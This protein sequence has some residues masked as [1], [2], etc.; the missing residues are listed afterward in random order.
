MKTAGTITIKR[1]S[2]LALLAACVGTI[3]LRAQAQQ[4]SQDGRSSRQGQ[5]PKQSQLS[6]PPHAQPAPM[7]TYRKYLESEEGRAM[8][9]VA[10][11]PISKYLND[12]FGA[13]SADALAQ[14]RAR[15]QKIA[16]QP[17]PAETEPAEG[18]GAV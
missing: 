10:G 4:A 5:Q 17:Q 9:Q 7:A 11:R 8:M 6:V 14:A 16:A 2:I 1:I 13:P 12:K 15:L 18:V 3:G